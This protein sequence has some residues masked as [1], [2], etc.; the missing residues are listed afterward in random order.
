MLTDHLYVLLFMLLHYFY[1][2]LIC[3]WPHEANNTGNK[4]YYWT[5]VTNN[6]ISSAK[7]TPYKATVRSSNPR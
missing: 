3:Y 2:I 1:E 5:D 7:E 4:G 6:T